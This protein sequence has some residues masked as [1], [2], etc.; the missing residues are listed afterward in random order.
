M[1]LSPQDRQQYKRLERFAIIVGVFLV[2]TNLP[3]TVW[4]LLDGA[5]AGAM[6]SGAF[7]V[8]GLVVLFKRGDLAG[9]RS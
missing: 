7:L 3:V 9:R 4:Y 5:L 2:V 8:L 6:F 1:A